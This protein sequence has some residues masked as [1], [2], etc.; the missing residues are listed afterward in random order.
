VA[1]GRRAVRGDLVS[2]Q[3]ERLAG[4]ETAEGR[5]HTRQ[6]GRVGQAE[7]DR[8]R[9]VGPVGG[10]AH[11]GQWA[12]PVKLPVCSV[13]TVRWVKSVGCATI[14]ITPCAIIMVPASP[15]VSMQPPT[16]ACRR[17]ARPTA[18]A[19]CQLI[20]AQLAEVAL[21][22]QRLLCL[23]VHDSWWRF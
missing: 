2:V 6:V 23:F 9:G 14:P 16:P 10:R 4:R 20:G 12:T 19:G 13:C 1:T 5:D 3:S 8:A 18:D 17:T 15:A 7:L 11:D 21:H 22:G